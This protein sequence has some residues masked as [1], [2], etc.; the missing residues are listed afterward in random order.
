MK[1]RIT[2]QPIGVVQGVSLKYYRPG[3]VYEL[4][5]SLAEYL[6]MEQY[7]I[8]EMRDRDRPHVPVAVERR[9]RGLTCAQPYALCCTFSV[10]VI[11]SYVPLKSTILPFSNCQTRV[12]TSSSRS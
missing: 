2:R 5:P 6:V 3:E 1:V 9:R 7:A 11:S 12:P 4:P 8:F 10:P